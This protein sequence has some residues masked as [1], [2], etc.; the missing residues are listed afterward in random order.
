MKV[1]TKREIFNDS[2]DTINNNCPLD[3]FFKISLLKEPTFENN[4]FVKSNRESDI[5]IQENTQE[6]SQS[7]TY[8]SKNMTISF[9]LLI[10]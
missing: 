6:L 1:K 3:Y 2:N 10:R 8:K 4:K 9:T 7:S 5:C